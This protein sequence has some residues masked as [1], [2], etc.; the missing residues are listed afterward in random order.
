MLT[1]PFDGSHTTQERL[2]LQTLRTW[3]S[4]AP[5]HTTASPPRDLASP[6][7]HRVRRHF[8]GTKASSRP[9]H[10]ITRVP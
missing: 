5:Y 9:L 2:E 4:K 3:S 8:G 6:L 7:Y 10:A 1:R